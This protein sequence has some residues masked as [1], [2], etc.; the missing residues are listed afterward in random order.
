MTHQLSINLI[1]PNAKREPVDMESFGFTGI[2]VVITPDV[3]SR[4]LKTLEP[5]RQYLI[6]FE[7]SSGDIVIRAI[8]AH[9]IVIKPIVSNKI[10]ISAEL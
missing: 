9:G 6:T 1:R 8:S 2:E 3:K 5:T 7:D 4:L 10:I